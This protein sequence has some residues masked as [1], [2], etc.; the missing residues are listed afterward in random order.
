MK[1][2][3]VT[4]TFN[5]VKEVEA[6]LQ[7]VLK[8]DWPDLEYIVVDGASTDGTMDVINRYR[9]QISK[10]VSEPDKGLYDAM[11]KALTMATGEWCAFL[12]A[13]DVYTDEHTV[14]ALFDGVEDLSGKK[15]VYG[16]TKYLYSDGSYGMQS[17]ATLDKLSWAICRYQPYSHQAVFYNILCKED[18]RYDLRYRIAAD[19]D[20]ACRY[21]NHYGIEA[22]HYVPIIVCSYKAY[23]GVSTNP[24]N[25][26]RA[27]KEKIIIK[28]RNH[29]NIMEIMKDFARYVLRKV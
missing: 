17:V 25:R 8:Q 29:M 20:V 22:Y 18:C 10:V 16:Q 6:T 12:N 14:S 27:F 19:Y 28:I 9:D 13:G 7:S 3:V 11:N 1:I 23:D 4:V 26:R 2:T 5:C 21:W 24:E 15:V